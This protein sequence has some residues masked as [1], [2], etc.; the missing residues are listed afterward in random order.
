LVLG[1]YYLDRG[2][3]QKELEALPPAESQ[4]RRLV[5]LLHANN[6]YFADPFF[7]Q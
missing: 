2:A 1:K 4:Q 3:A 5:S 6:L 7:G